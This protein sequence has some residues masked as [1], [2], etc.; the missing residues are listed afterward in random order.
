MTGGG[1]PVAGGGG[2]VTTG[3]EPQPSRQS[4]SHR[5]RERRCVRVRESRDVSRNK[6]YQL[7]TTL[8]CRGT[9]HTFLDCETL[10]EILLKT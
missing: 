6:W 5:Q 9:V 10:V 7:I 3:A 4:E 2:E 1:K 8:P